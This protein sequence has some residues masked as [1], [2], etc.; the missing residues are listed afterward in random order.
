[1]DVSDNPA[2]AAMVAT[3]SK[4]GTCTGHCSLCGSD[5]ICPYE[6]NSPLVVSYDFTETTN[7][8]VGSRTA[9]AGAGTAFTIS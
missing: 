1:M 3:N 8:W 2:S 7:T 6:D 5:G 4:C 9:S